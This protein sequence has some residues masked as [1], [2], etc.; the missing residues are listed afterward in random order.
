MVIPLNGG[1]PRQ[2]PTDLVLDTSRTAWSSDGAELMV[3]ATPRDAPDGE[4]DLWAIPVAGGSP[5]RL[6]I[7]E[8]LTSAGIRHPMVE[9]ATAG[10]SIIASLRADSHSDIWQIPRPGEPFWKRGSL[11]RLA[12][13]EGNAAR[14]AADREGRV[15]YAA[16]SSKPD[17]LSLFFDTKR[18]D[19]EKPVT[20]RY[21][22]RDTALETGPELSPDGRRLVFASNRS[23]ASELWMAD[24]DSNHVVQLTFDSLPGPGIQDAHMSQDGRAVAFRRTLAG[25]TRH[26]L[27]LVSVGGGTPKKF[28]ESGF[29]A[30]WL[31]DRTHLIYTDFDRNRATGTDTLLAFDTVASRSDE[32]QQS[33]GQRLQDMRTSPDGKW[34]MLCYQEPGAFLGRCFVAPLRRGR[35]PGRSEWVQVAET[36]LNARWAP[37]ADAVFYYSEAGGS[38]AG[39][40]WLQRLDASTKH[41]QGSPEFV[42]GGKTRSRVLPLGLAVGADRI[43]LPATEMSGNIW[44]VRATP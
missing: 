32:F 26:P 6:G 33:W 22:T 14:A 44:T 36:A 13:A 35:A 9:F 4:A 12:F 19:P 18:P 5:R 28:C 29:I 3:L 16:S 21:M 38:R 1:T 7:R 24:G 31:S 40:I 25:G 11:R 37:S 8:A 20:A 2:V 34:L 15:V 27:F 39:G 10:S 43:V 23:G 17:L 41:P 42:Y 30:G